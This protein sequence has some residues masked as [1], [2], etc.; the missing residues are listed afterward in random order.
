M[1]S[2]DAK[3]L[4]YS[5][6]IQVYT[7]RL[8]TCPCPYLCTC[9]IH[10]SMHMFMPHVHAACPCRM[11]M[12]YVHAACPCRMSMPHVHATCPCHMSMP[13]VHATCPC[14]VSMPRVHAT[15]LGSGTSGLSL[16][17]MSPGLLDTLSRSQRYVYG[18]VYG[19]V[20]GHVYGHVY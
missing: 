3:D 14:H 4:A 11:S 8:C 12:P 15:C 5:A 7:T 10:T 13:R 20:F 1:L 2:L 17:P 16:M 19:R 18:C 9:P 6:L